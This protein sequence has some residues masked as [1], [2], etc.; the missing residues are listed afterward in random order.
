MDRDELRLS[1]A[2]VEKCLLK[3]HS[4]VNSAT[5]LEAFQ[6]LVGTGFHDVHLFHQKKDSINS[7]LLPHQ[8]YPYVHTNFPQNPN[9]SPAVV[10]V[11]CACG[12][13]VLTT[14]TATVDGSSMTKIE[15][16]LVRT[17]LKI[18]HFPTFQ[19]QTN[20]LH[21]KLVIY[22]FPVSKLRADH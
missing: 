5:N 10:Q 12:E 15:T 22:T 1:S 11:P 6:D 8:E 17:G 13:T 16:L 14:V 19:Y 3:K 21:P 4:N 18:P 2:N 7:F 20:G 9:T